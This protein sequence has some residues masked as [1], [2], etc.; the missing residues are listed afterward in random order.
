MLPDLAY[1][2]SRHKNCRDLNKLK[3][4]VFSLFCKDLQDDS[5]ANHMFYLYR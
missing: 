2:C 1:F 5:P 3:C 4:L